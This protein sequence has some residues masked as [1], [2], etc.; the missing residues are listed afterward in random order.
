VITSTLSA[1]QLW[2]LALLGFFHGIDPGMGWLFAVSFGLQERSRAALLGVLPFVA[3]GHEGAIGVMVVTTG[4]VA[5]LA[6]EVLGLRILRS[7]SVNLDRVWA[8]ALVGAG[9]ATVLT[10]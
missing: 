1:G 6:Y 9:V 4:V 8:L 3:L 10:A 2:T 7:L 5:L